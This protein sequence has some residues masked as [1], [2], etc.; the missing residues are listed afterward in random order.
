MADD[1]VATDA[2]LSG[3]RGSEPAIL[4]KLLQ[5][6]AAQT[7]AHE[8]AIVMVSATIV[9]AGQ[10]ASVQTTLAT[11]ADANRPAWQ[12]AAVLRGAE[13]ALV[14]NTPMPGTARRG[15]APSITATAVGHCGCAVPD[16]S[17]RPRRPGRRLRV[18]RCPRPG[19]SDLG[20]SQEARAEAGVAAVAPAVDAVAAGRGSRSFANRR[21]LSAL[22]GGS[23]DLASR[24]ANVLARIE[25][26]GKPGA[27]N[28][29]TP[30]T[31]RRA[32][33]LRGGPRGLPQHLPDVP[34]ARWPRAGARRA[35]A[36]RFRARAGAGGS[37]AR[38]SSQRQGR[39]RRI[40]AA[41]R[42]DA[43]RRSN[44]ECV[45]LRAARVGTGGRSRR[46]GDGRGRTGADG[47]PHHGRGPTTSC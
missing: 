25:W 43:H 1:P 4:E 40:D 42:R 7:A 2:A 31:R 11:V 44:R 46:S 12:R 27:A 33:A 13:V 17:R 41:D 45:D 47:H 3:A 26:P 29:V 39:H 28:P 18:R 24:A 23:D 14:P 9:R 32:A 37:D 36:R 20:D 8:A 35:T 15:A 34:S 21:H 5:T 10:D 30:L 22:A 16:L 6:D 38:D 19:G